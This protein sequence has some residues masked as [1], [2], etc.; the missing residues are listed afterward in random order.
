MSLMSGHSRAFL[1]QV[2][3]S[4]ADWKLVALGWYAATPVQLVAEQNDAPWVSLGQLIPLL[5]EQD[6][7]LEQRVPSK[8]RDYLSY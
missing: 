6:L 2:S 3:S 1:A 4:D 5:V 7:G 8:L